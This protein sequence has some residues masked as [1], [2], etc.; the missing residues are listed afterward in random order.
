MSREGEQVVHLHDESGPPRAVQPGT[1]H[2]H[3]LDRQ[4]GG[5]V[6]RMDELEHVTGALHPMHALAYGPHRRSLE[7][8]A[9]GRHYRLVAVIDDSQ[10]GAAVHGEATL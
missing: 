7:S 3:E 9:A 4:L 5:H 1:L 2:L 6:A 8:K 10:P